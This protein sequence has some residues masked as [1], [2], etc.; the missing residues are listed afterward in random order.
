VAAAKAISH[1]RL[2]ETKPSASIETTSQASA[3]VAERASSGTTVPRSPA[4]PQQPAS[5]GTTTS[6]ATERTTASSEATRSSLT[7]EQTGWTTTRRNV[8]PIGRRPRTNCCAASIPSRI[9]KRSN[10]FR[11][12]GSSRP[13]Q[14]FKARA[15]LL[16]SVNTGRLPPFDHFQKRSTARRADSAAASSK[17]L[18]EKGSPQQQ[19]NASP[20]RKTDTPARRNTS[21]T[22]LAR[23][24]SADP[25]ASRRVRQHGK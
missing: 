18:E 3:R 21:R 10:R 23:Q 8:L 13:R 1:V 17:P 25:L 11:R 4:N 5:P 22:T 2:L 16:P 7:A 12:S 20:G 14:P 6:R 15:Q 24:A 9:R 19:P